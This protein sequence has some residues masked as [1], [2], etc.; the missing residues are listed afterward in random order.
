[1]GPA[2]LPNLTSGG[3]LRASLWNIFHLVGVSVLQKSLKILLCAPSRGARTLPQG[4]AVVPLLSLHPFPSLLSNL[5]M[6]SG[7]ISPSGAFWVAGSMG[8]GRAFP[9]TF[10]EAEW[11][12]TE[13]PLRPGSTVFDVQSAEM[14]E[15]TL[16]LAPGTSNEG[17]NGKGGE[18]TLLN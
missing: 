5:R 11:M 12:V 9:S 15:V 6:A 18:V 13:C 8:R 16:N 7:P 1:M 2:S 4:C 17:P 10:P 3:L 14:K